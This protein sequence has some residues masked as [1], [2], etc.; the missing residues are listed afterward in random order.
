MTRKLIVT[1]AAAEAVVTA[2]TPTRDV[3]TQDLTPPEP[4]C[5]PGADIRL[6]RAL[7]AWERTATGIWR[8][9]AC[10]VVN[11]KL[12]R[13]FQFPVYAPLAATEPPDDPNV[14]RFYVIWRGRWEVMS[15]QHQVIKYGP[16]N[17]IS[18]ETTP[19]GPFD[20]IFHNAGVVDATIRGDSYRDRGTMYLSPAYFY[21]EPKTLDIVGKRELCLR[22]KSVRVVTDVKLVDGKLELATEDVRVLY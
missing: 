7:T 6:A 18:I 3:A 8:T 11:D 21:W 10:F 12:D 2:G 19:T 22:V 1:Q 17:A 14:K 5:M 9:T 15:S 4:V 16:G 20:H 13:S